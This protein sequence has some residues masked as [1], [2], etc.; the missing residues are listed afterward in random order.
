[1]TGTMK[2]VMVQ[3]AVILLI[4]GV[5]GAFYVNKAKP[6]ADPLDALWAQ[7][8]APETEKITDLGKLAKAVAAKEVICID[9]RSAKEYA[10]GHLPGAVSL[11]LEDLDKALAQH[12][13][14]Y[15]LNKKLVI[16]CTDDGCDLSDLLAQKLVLAGLNNLEV[17]PGGI[18]AWKHANLPTER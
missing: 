16:Y 18:N 8:G 12:L 1:M 6:K 10:E 3:G 14:L 4:G 7:A 5:L 13:N 2:K 11:P 15:V 9:A 17:F